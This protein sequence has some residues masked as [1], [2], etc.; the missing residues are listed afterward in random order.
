MADLTITISDPKGGVTFA[1]ERMA[2]FPPR[3]PK[4]E[5]TDEEF[6]TEYLQGVVN[7]WAGEKNEAEF[8]AAFERAKAERDA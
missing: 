5:R 2:Y 6:L 7:G 3:G 4:I 1:R 8:R